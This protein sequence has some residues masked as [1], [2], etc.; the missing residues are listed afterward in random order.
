MEPGIT[1]CE[2]LFFKILSFISGWVYCFSFIGGYFC[3][4]YEIYKEKTSAGLSWNYLMLSFLGYCYYMLYFVWG[5]I[6]PSSGILN[7]IH[8]E[9]WVF[10]CLA[11]L[12]HGVC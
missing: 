7:S 9:D 12:W 3:I 6:N 11:I 8:A 2:E 1:S 4:S 10:L 5:A